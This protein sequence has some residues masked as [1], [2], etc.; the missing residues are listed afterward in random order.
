MKIDKEIT[1]LIDLAKE[2]SFLG[3]NNIKN[4]IKNIYKIK[5]DKNITEETKNIIKEKEYYDRLNEIENAK[6][7]LELALEK[8]NK[9]IIILKENNKK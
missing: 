9:C 8:L 1:D 7:T 2:Y 6:K 4:I 5:N 3:A